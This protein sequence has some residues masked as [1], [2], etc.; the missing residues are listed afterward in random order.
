MLIAYTAGR[1]VLSTQIVEQS[2]SYHL[3]IENG[4]N[5]SEESWF[6]AMFTAGYHPLCSLFEAFI[7]VGAEAGSVKHPDFYYSH[8]F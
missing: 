7:Y 6:R 5:M 1:V 2:K 4:S 3:K 8:A